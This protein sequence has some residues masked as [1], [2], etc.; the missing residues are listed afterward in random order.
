MKSISQRH[1]RLYINILN[2]SNN[3]Y[4]VEYYENQYNSDG[5]L[6]INS[7]TISVYSMSRT[8]SNRQNLYELNK[9]EYKTLIKLIKKQQKALTIY[10]NK[11]QLDKLDIINSSFNLLLEYKEIFLKWFS[12]NEFS[13]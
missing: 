7:G 11:N 6:V 10:S 2:K 8:I 12:D 9:E 4:N 5:S 13:K 1:P 3:Y